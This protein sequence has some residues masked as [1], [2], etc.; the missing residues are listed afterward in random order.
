MFGGTLFEIILPTW[1]GIAVLPVWALI[2][3]LVGFL[4]EWKC[5]P[6][7]DKHRWGALAWTVWL[8]T[9]FV[10]VAAIMWWLTSTGEISVA[11]DFRVLPVVLLV[12][13]A[14]VVLGISFIG[15]CQ[16]YAIQQ[17]KAQRQAN[18]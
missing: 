13:L 4:A 9:F 18:W 8:G 6:A 10:A 14:G 7:K 3:G 15:M 11:I 2:G 16:H 12:L 5:V 17:M 1:A